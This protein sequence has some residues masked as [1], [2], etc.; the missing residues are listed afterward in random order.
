M[1]SVPPSRLGKIQGDRSWLVARWDRSA[2]S[3]G[4]SM[5][6][7]HV[8]CTVFVGPSPKRLTERRTPIV[9]RCQRRPPT[10]ARSARLG[11]SPEMKTTVPDES[12]HL[13]PLY[14]LA[15]FHLHL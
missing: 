9:V 12:N 3:T 2:R 14:R 11:R 5:S 1:S 6:A 15:D 7:S 13:P 8:D 10:A 4:G